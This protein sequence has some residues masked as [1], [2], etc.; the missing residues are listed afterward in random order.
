MYVT[1]NEVLFFRQRQLQMLIGTTSDVTR[2]QVLHDKLV[3]VTSGQ[4]IF[5]AEDSYHRSIS[6]IRRDSLRPR[7][8]V[9][10]M[11]RHYVLI[12][13]VSFTTKNDFQRC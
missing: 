5:L 1:A 6:P 7:T 13:A 10:V 11:I 8:A 3:P 4:M 2:E 9:L 12:A